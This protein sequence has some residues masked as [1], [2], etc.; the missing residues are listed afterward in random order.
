MLG[1]KKVSGSPVYHIMY[2]TYFRGFICGVPNQWFMGMI[3]SI[4]LVGK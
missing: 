3:H 2:F 1:L 4:P